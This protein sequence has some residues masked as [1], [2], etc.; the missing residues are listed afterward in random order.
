[1]E[2]KKQTTTK[3]MILEYKNTSNITLEQDRKGTSVLYV[4]EDKKL[5]GCLLGS[6]I[7]ELI[8]NKNL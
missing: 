4:Y 1:M 5:I 8:N 3:K 6:E 2:N 7:I